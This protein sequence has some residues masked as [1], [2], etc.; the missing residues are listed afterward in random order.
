MKGVLSRPRSWLAGALLALAW[1]GGC[2]LNPQPLPP[3]EN[4]FGGGGGGDDSGALAPGGPTA[5]SGS[6]GS[7]GSNSGGFGGS[8]GGSSGS[9]GAS[10]SGTSSG[11]T[12]NPSGDAGVPV[13]QDAAVAD[14][15]EHALDGAVDT[16]V[17]DAGE[18]PPDGGSTGDAGCVR[19]SDCYLS[20]P[21]QCSACRWPLNYPVCIEGRCGCACDEKDA[22]GE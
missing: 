14:A 9:G 1:A 13:E 22:A 5:S 3:T 4:A 12:S 15:G 2:D 18:P 16:G 11:S 21:G 8:S 17:P 20:H 7:S 19:R 10:S 6:G